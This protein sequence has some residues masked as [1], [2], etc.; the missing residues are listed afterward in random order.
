M[1]YLEFINVL[2]ELNKIDLIPKE[3][4]YQNKK[5]YCKTII[6][7]VIKMLNI[8]YPIIDAHSFM[9]NFLIASNVKYKNRHQRLNIKDFLQYLYK[10]QYIDSDSTLNNILGNIDD[11]SIEG[12]CSIADNNDIYIVKRDMYYSIYMDYSITNLLHNSFSDLDYDINSDLI[13]NEYEHIFLLDT[14]I[15]FVIL[16]F[17]HFKFIKSTEMHY[18]QDLNVATK[19]L[20]YELNH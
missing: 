8:L 11:Y 7:H 4:K 20:Q 16:L 15:R 18:I 12:N 19:Q 3:I 2:N 17:L 1:S 13:I 6:M 5:E 14:K 9:I 10:Y